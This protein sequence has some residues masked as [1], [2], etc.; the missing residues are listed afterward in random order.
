LK[1]RS[2]NV[3]FIESIVCKP[4]REEYEKL[5]DADSRRWQV[6]HEAEKERNKRER[7]RMYYHNTWRDA[8]PGEFDRLKH[9]ADFRAV[10]FNQRIYEIT[11]QWRATDGECRGDSPRNVVGM[12][13]EG[14]LAAH[15]AARNLKPYESDREETHDYDGYV[16]DRE[17]YDP[18]YDYEAR[19]RRWD[20]FGQGFCKWIEREFQGE[21]LRIEPDFVWRAR[22]AEGDTDDLPGLSVIYT[23]WIDGSVYAKLKPDLDL[24]EV[25]TWALKHLGMRI[26]ERALRPVDVGTP[27]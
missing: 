5:R 16:R 25:A 21:L 15:Y 12:W 1:T 27:A 20:V 8:K 2:P 3:S 26:E 4:C 9:S 6:A 23:V 19:A 13:V 14:K 10:L 7:E 17:E 11:F 18:R 22:D 24:K